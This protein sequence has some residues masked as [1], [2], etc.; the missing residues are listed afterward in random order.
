[1]SSIQ[2]ALNLGL[3]AL[4]QGNFV[5]AE[6]YFNQVLAVIPNE[7]N[8]LFL[9]G[10]LRL[11]QER[12]YEA[13]SLMHQALPNHPNKAEVYNSLGNLKGKMQ[14]AEQ[15]VSYY[16]EAIKHKANFGIAYLNLG[17]AYSELN[18]HENAVK[19]LKQAC[20]LLPNNA[21]AWSSLADSYKEL[22]L[23]DEALG[24]YDKAL[25][26]DSNRIITLNN[27]GTLLR[28][29]Q[30]PND[31]RACYQKAL[32]VNKTVPEVNF[33]MACASYD[34]GA[35][36]DT[37]S[38]L[39]QTIALDPAYVEAHETL[40]RMYWEH[41]K[42]D[43]FT[44]S[45]IDAIRLK[46]DSPELR[47]MLANQLKMANRTEESLSVLNLA[48]SELGALPQISHAMGMLLGQ[49]GNTELAVEHLSNAVK[50]A[51]MNERYLI[52]AA[53]FLIRAYQYE[54]AMA[55]LDI[56]QQINPYEQEMW[57]LKGLCWRF[58]GDER[59]AWLNNYDLFVQAKVLDTPDG[60]DNFEHFIE[61][62]KNALIKMHNT[63]KTPLDQSV[64]HGT[65]TPGRLLY[66]PIKEIMD[67]RTV[68][69]KRIREYLHSLPD[70]PTH[71]FL[72]RKTQ[73]FRFSGSWSVRLKSEGFHVN[74]VHPD[75]WFSGPTY[76]E[77][78]KEV[79][80]DDPNKAG[81]VT[82]GETGMNLG[83]EREQI[84]VSVCPEPGLCA[85]FPSYVWHGT[86]PFQSND[87]RMTTPCDVF[88]V[89]P[90][91]I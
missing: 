29:L 71:P 73:N 45:Y 41:G 48:L 13:E 2:Q 70:D 24:V 12:M 15:A 43:Q 19:S 54:Q 91:A 7:P 56:V 82:F 86:I 14:Q 17:L 57:A 11:R 63:V 22:A 44:Q 77:V 60:Y 74:H 49:T 50:L 42:F 27:K 87:H 25:S 65:Q 1:M 18:Q 39:Q 53:N 34:A 88:P 52:D 21:S 8:S 72:S 32:T 80:S 9:L 5:N 40:N 6:Q 76:I 55:H 3:Q 69:E 64:R 85:F 4:N 20:Q 46:P 68:L 16:L 35:Y 59:E 47:V 51:P 31:A 90:L 28:V 83:E 78:P 36:E 30:R 67:Y 38:Y 23:Y 84:A 61:S 33:N 26:I 66:Q 89:A 37:E 75:G 10:A 62:L 81:W 58:T 79:R